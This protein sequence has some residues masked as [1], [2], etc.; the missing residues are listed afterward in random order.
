MLLPEDGGR[1]QGRCRGEGS[2]CVCLPCTACYSVFLFADSSGEVERCHV[3]VGVVGA[4]AT[5]D[6]S[7]GR[8]KVQVGFEKET[9][10]QDQ[11]RRVDVGQEELR[12]E[13]ERKM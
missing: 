2:C 13:E 3:N 9:S 8:S 7:R 10:S 1:R 5:E 12:K 4:S 6:D 11:T